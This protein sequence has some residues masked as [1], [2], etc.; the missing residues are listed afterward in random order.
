MREA[1][2]AVREDAVGNVIG[3]LGGTGST[4][5]VGSH[6]D[7]VRDAGRWDGPLGVVTAIACLATLGQ[8][9][10]RPRRPVEVIGFCDEE[11]T[12]F[13][14]AMLGSLALAGRVDPSLLD[15]RDADGVS[16][17]DAMRRWGLDPARVGEAAR[18]D[19][20][21][22]LEL[23]IEQGPV[24]QRVD[25][26]IGVVTAISGQTR[27]RVTL[28]G[29]A[30]HAGTVPMAGRH[31]ALTAAAACLLAVERLAAAEPDAVATAGWLEVP[32]G[33][34]NTIPG[35]V[36]FSLDVRAPDDAQRA[37]LLHAIGQDMTS[38]CAGRGVAVEVAATHTLPAAPCGPHLRACISAAI[39]AEGFAVHA[40]PSGAGHDGMTLRDVC[41]IGMIFVRCAGG[42]SHHPAEHVAESDIEAGARVLTR[43]IE[44]LA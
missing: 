42:V 4:L 32:N 23:H 8:R 26:P 5:L 20:A 44:E 19:L 28:T 17:S 25:C 18:N 38:I 37:R 22:F 21:A 1:G 11:G 27:W 3:R 24:L 9:G 13:G 43:I 16:I 6:L 29:Q 30:G 39:A 40:V 10:W 35:R 15:V 7:S 36:D 2:L 14:A 33:A 41:E 34:V 31:D 12:R